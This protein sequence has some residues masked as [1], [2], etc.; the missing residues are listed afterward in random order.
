MSGRIQD[1]AKL[2]ASVDERKLHGA[3]IV[4]YTGCNACKIS[5]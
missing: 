5:S 1:W 3:K 2:F 4:M